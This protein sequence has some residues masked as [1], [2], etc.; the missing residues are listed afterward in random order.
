MDVG[1]VPPGVPPCGPGAKESAGVRLRLT[2]SLH[3]SRGLFSQA[4]GERSE[5]QLV[6]DG[7]RRLAV[8]AVNPSDPAASL[9]QPFFTQ[10]MASILLPSRS[11]TNAA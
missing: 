11:R 1:R 5:P 4:G 8:N 2:T 3:W 6:R 10:H 7:S 9:P